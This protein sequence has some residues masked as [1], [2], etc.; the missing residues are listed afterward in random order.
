[1]PFTLQEL[2]A[3]AEP[4]PWKDALVHVIEAEAIHRDLWKACEADYNRFYETPEHLRGTLGGEIVKVVDS[5]EW[6]VSSLQKT[7]DGIYGVRNDAFVS[8]A[9]DL[10]AAPPVDGEPVWIRLMRD[11]QTIREWRYAHLDGIDVQLAQFVMREPS[12]KEPGMFDRALQGWSKAAGSK[13]ADIRAEVLEIAR[14]GLLPGIVADPATYAYEVPGD[15]EAALADLVERRGVDEILAQVRLAGEV[16]PTDAF[17]V[18]ED[19]IRQLEGGTSLR[20]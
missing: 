14:A 8:K 2:A 3:R 11:L 17:P 19:A 20:P 7:R 13:V 1:M 5:L 12:R 9:A 18:P 10:G 16:L 6:S 4:G 15:H